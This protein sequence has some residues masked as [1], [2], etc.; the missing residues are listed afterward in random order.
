MYNL[1]H[2]F[3]PFILQ[4]ELTWYLPFTISWWR[5]ISILISGCRFWGRYFIK[6]WKIWNEGWNRNISWEH[7]WLSEVSDTLLQNME[8][9][10][11]VK[12][13]YNLNLQSFPVHIWH[14]RNVFLCFSFYFQSFCENWNFFRYI[15]S[16]LWFFEKYNII[17]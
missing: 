15:K 2:V 7:V 9:Y 4:D 8:Q 16:F 14:S 11:V 3:F 5:L 17:I 12:S 6:C 1:N 13:V 10:V